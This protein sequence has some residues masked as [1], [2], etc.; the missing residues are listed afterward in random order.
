[1]F[2]YLAG[3]D[4][5]IF[6]FF[7][8]QAANPVTDFIMPLATSD[9]ILRFIYA[10]AVLW[11]LW[12]GDRQTR[13][14]VLFSALTLAI[15]DQASAHWLKPM[16]ARPRPCH[17]LPIETIRLLVDCGSG[18]SMP[19][20]HAANAFGQAMLFGMMF[21]RARWWLLALAVIIALSRVFVG[22]H[23]P[24]DI[25]AGSVVGMFTGTIVFVAYRRVMQL[26]LKKHPPTAAG[27]MQQL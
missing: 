8:M 16:F 25:I 5:T 11:L 23:Y 9:A 14:L 13:W 3:L 26:V 10:V 27:G 15:T 12:K 1:M 20:S 22:V 4:R 7:N 6:L 19:S 21:V 17:T 24:S 18:F 2:E